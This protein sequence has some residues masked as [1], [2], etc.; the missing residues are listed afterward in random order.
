MVSIV[1][2][3]GLQHPHTPTVATDAYTP[4]MS[5]PQNGLP[6]P[7]PTPTYTTKL[8]QIA[9]LAL[10]F[11]QLALMLTQE[12]DPE[13]TTQQW[14]ALLAQ[15]VKE[16]GG[17]IEKVHQHR[18][19]IVFPHD[20]TIMDS[21]DSAMTLAY[22]LTQHPLQVAQQ[23]QPIKAGLVIEN[24][25]A[26][27]PLAGIAQRDAAQPHH[28]I[29]SATVAMM[30]GY[31]RFGFI[32]HAT[33]PD[34]W[35]VAKLPSDLWDNVPLGGAPPSPESFTLDT[36]TRVSEVPPAPPPAPPIEPPPRIEEETSQVASLP[37]PPALTTADEP[38]S[39]TPSV[40]ASTFE[41]APVTP[42][43]TKPAPPAPP[44]NRATHDDR[45]TLA[46]D[47][48]IEVLIDKTLNRA[49]PPVQPVPPSPVLDSDNDGFYEAVAEGF[50]EPEVVMLNTPLPEQPTFSEQP[51]TSDTPWLTEPEPPTYETTPLTIP[52]LAGLPPTSSTLNLS[53]SQQALD[54]IYVAPA[55][56]LPPPQPL[57]QSATLALPAPLRTPE[58]VTSPAP[59]VAITLPLVPATLTELL[60]QTPPTLPPNTLW[61][62]LLGQQDEAVALGGQHFNVPLQQASMALLQV[63][64]TAISSPQPSQVLVLQA[65]AGMG[66][67]TALNAL[68]MQ[69]DPA[70]TAPPAEGSTPPEAAIV[71]LK[72]SPLHHQPNQ[73]QPL[74]LW[75][76][77]LR[78]LLNLPL[79]GVP[80]QFATQ[81]LATLLPKL[82]GQPN[83]SPQQH[84]FWQEQLGLPPLPT[85]NASA[86]GMAQALLGL[87]KQGL[88]QQP[89]TAINE[90]LHL[91][92]QLSQYKPVV[93][94]L[95]DVD[96]ADPAS[97][98]LLQ[99][100]L[101]AG[102][103]QQANVILLLAK[104]PGTQWQP[105]LANALSQ[106]TQAT[107]FPLQTLHLAPLNE[108]A[109]LT[110]LQ[111]GA[112]GDV[113]QQLPMAWLTHLATI[114]QGSPLLLEEALR[115]MM[116]QGLL[117]PHPETGAL[118]LN[119]PPDLQPAHAL[120]A[121]IPQV[122]QQRALALSNEARQLLQ[123]ASV[124]GSSFSPSSLMGLAQQ[125]EAPFQGHIHTLWQSGW[126][127][128]DTA[129]DLAFRHPILREFFYLSTPEDVRVQLHQLVYQTFTT[130]YSEPTLLTPA[131]KAHHAQAGQWPDQVITHLLES[132]TR[133]AN[134]GSVQGLTLTLLHLQDVLWPARKSDDIATL[135][136]T[137]WHV[138]ALAW[139]GQAPSV[140]L[141]MLG[142]WAFQGLPVAQ[143]PAVY[144]L[145]GEFALATH[146]V[147]LAGAYY[148]Q[149]H[150]LAKAANQPLLE[151]ATLELKLAQ[152]AAILGR[153]GSVAQWLTGAG[154]AAYTT[155]QGE[156]TP[157]VAHYQAACGAWE[158]DY[159]AL[160]ATVALNTTGGWTAQQAKRLNDLASHWQLPKAQHAVQGALI[161]QVLHQGQLEQ[162]HTL[163]GQW[164]NQLETN[165]V[166]EATTL[167][168]M[169]QWG[170][171][172][173]K[174]HWLAGD[175]Q[176]A[177]LLLPNVAQKATLAGDMNLS[178][179][180]LCLEGRC[181][182]SL[183]D[184]VKG[185][186]CVS[187][188]LETATQLDLATTSLEA[189]LAMAQTH[190]L[191]NQPEQALA[192]AQEALTIA[193][194]PVYGATLL[195]YE[196]S[197]V[198][199][200]A[201][202]AQGNVSLAG[203]TLV[204]VWQALASTPLAPYQAEVALTIA[205]IY[206][207]TAEHTQSLS[208]QHHVV[209]R[210]RQFY[211]RCLQ[212]WKQWGNTYQMQQAQLA[213]RPFL[214]FVT[215]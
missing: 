144:A 43:P 145:L 161:Q 42:P 128:T 130:G 179:Q 15:R 6:S 195:G 31:K 186:E 191:A 162:A 40:R 148:Q 207:H 108:E 14:V 81:H 32:S 35:V 27:D 149:A 67:T 122:L 165:D 182:T 77:L 171:Y 99:G 54:D 56:A 69:L 133:Q 33:S 111:Q 209:A 190:L 123:M 138:L 86:L 142:W 73:P 64:Q 88:P 154:A 92:K 175:R 44:S 39:P 55:E 52:T 214:A 197:N 93:L 16:A 25:N 215:Q 160:A 10:E 213:Y 139:H 58:A 74:E 137:L 163:L 22:E 167:L 211:Q 45:I 174:A 102:L 177:L 178:L 100:L 146:Q 135:M 66:K 2:I 153:Y 169:A 188:A 134:L 87:V 136:D 126:L 151:V 117:L 36:P 97:Q 12:A 198:V 212:L 158:A 206:A 79:E 50:E 112:L 208:H 141:A 70:L 116:Q 189:W 205:L 184:P 124:L 157:G 199:A 38:A 94:V 13:A 75:T 105:T 20:P 59:P 91:L 176:Q 28:V 62:P 200:R 63:V 80:V 168:A 68:R 19:F 119:L 60:P 121:T 203:Q 51:I 152:C 72:A 192:V 29:A 90:W 210:S 89:Q 82:L 127:T 155:L 30:L 34:G 24:V 140:A 110:F 18:V 180:A 131:L 71:W 1:T 125:D 84:A 172:A 150:V 106:A 101:E 5:P 114:T 78:Q 17:I 21:L 113:A 129:N 61:Q 147:K 183:G 159:L 7:Q 118:A 196:L 193:Q 95:D 103:L 11:P 187:Q 53:E 83:L 156:G 107:A 201:T 204:P 98:W 132:A 166:D 3:N 143:Q 76:H 49:T 173:A 8:P 46:D 37:P 4:M 26:R 57:V 9:L 109:L 85:A 41:E 115:L 181:H 164:L 185:M 65:E 96:Q 202:L 104:Q 170:Y 23:W 47:G 120:P 48:L 194:K